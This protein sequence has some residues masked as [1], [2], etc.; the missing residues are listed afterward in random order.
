[1]KVG[2]KSKKTLAFFM[3]SRR[4]RIDNGFTIVANLLIPSLLVN[5]S[6]DFN[7]DEMKFNNISNKEN[8]G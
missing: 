1:V 5:P 7:M 4:R 3:S 2:M 8:H 6:S